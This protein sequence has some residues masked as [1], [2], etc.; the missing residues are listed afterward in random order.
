MQTLLKKGETTVVSRGKPQ[1]L[2][3]TA[4][5]MIANV[6]SGEVLQKEA[7][8]AHLARPTIIAVTVGLAVWLLVGFVDALGGVIRFFRDGELT[9]TE[10]VLLTVGSAFAAITPAVLFILHVR[11]TVWPNSVKALELAT[12]MKR[13]A[14]AAFATYGVAAVVVRVVYTVVLRHAAELT[15][16]AWDTALFFAS[17]VGALIAGGAG[18]IARSLRRKAND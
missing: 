17:F 16:G 12:D 18:P 8:A 9:L 11:K 7:R 4:R 10:S 1:K 3:V 14:A 15:S 2:D 5:T 13:T 6:G